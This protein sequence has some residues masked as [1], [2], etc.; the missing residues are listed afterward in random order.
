MPV[1]PPSLGPVA[2][3]AFHQS[4][5][6]EKMHETLINTR[7]KWFSPNDREKPDDGLN[8]PTFPEYCIERYG[9]TNPGLLIYPPAAFLAGAVISGFCYCT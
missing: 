9:F 4:G 5:E 2:V 3:Q 7:F 1:C 6:R 8:G